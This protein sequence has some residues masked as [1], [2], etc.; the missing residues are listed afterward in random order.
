MAAD[1]TGL[2]DVIVPEVFFGY[3]LEEDNRVNRLVQSGAVVADANSAS[4]LAGG[5]QTASLPSWQA[6]DGDVENV[7]TDDATIAAGNDVQGRRQII[8]RVERNGVWSS[9]DLTAMLAGSDPL[10]NAAARIAQFRNTKRQE[11]LMTVLL[12]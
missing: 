4:F 6:T 1:I 11:T 12:D 8:A 9:A 7:S 5:G 3:I 10:A 2:A